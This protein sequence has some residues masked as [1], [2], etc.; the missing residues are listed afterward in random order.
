MTRIRC[1]IV[2]ALVLLLPLLTKVLRR[3]RSDGRP[4][5]GSSSQEP[6]LAILHSTHEGRL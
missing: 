4:H 5:D 3:G 2:V 6:E 1:A